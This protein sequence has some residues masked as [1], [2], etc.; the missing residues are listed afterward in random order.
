LRAIHHRIALAFA[1]LLVHHRDRA[2]AI[3]DHQV[4]SLGLYGLQID[5]THGAVA[6]GIEARLFRNSR[7]RTSDVEGTH[8]ELRSRFANGLSRDHAGGLAQFNKASGSQITSVAHDANAAPRLAGKHRANLHPLDTGSLNRARQIFRD[9]VVDID[10]NLAFIVLDLLQRHTAHDTVAQ[11]LDNFAGFDDTGDENSVHGATVVFADDHVLRHVHQTARQVTRVGGLQS[12][13]GQTLA[14]TVRRDEVLSTVNPSRKL[15]VIGVSIIS[16]VGFA[17][18]PRI[19]ESWRICC[20]DPRAP[21]SAM[22]KIGLRAPVLS[23]CCMAENISS[24]TFSV[25]ADQISTT[26]L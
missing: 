21:E 10:H 2:L 26:L 13:I 22:T 11:R 14:G 5:E 7:R 6:L 25:M 24:A 17:I 4:A 23:S 12:R 18:S 1:A 16:P 8:G 15:A 19:P 3:H 20:F 9:L